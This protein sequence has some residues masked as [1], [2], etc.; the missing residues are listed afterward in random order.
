MLA[1]P[2]SAIRKETRN[3]VGGEGSRCID[4]RTA[5]TTTPPEIRSPCRVSRP[6]TQAR[7]H[8]IEVA[9][10]MLQ[11]NEAMD[12]N[13]RTTFWLC[14]SL[15]AIAYPLRAS[16][17]LKISVTPMYS[18]AP[19]TLRVVVK[20]ERSAENRA[21]EIFAESEDFYRSS[22]FSLDGEESPA[23]VELNVNNAPGGTY[24][25]AAVLKDSAGRPRAS[26][27]KEVTVI[28]WHQ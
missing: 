25:I 22:E 17:R 9:D 1:S 4:N 7:P 16:D 19:S 20:L 14:M 18:F 28:A 8:G 26:A 6:K 11:A 3:R 21:I 23:I 5:L 24:R 15:V 12:A 13:M 10:A 2:S 27:E